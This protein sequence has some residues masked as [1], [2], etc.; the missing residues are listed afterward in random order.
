[1][2]FALSR[3]LNVVIFPSTNSFNVTLE[4]TAFV[5]EQISLLKAWQLSNNRCFDKLL[6]WGRPVGDDYWW[7]L[8]P[9]SRPWSRLFRL[10]R[11]FSTSFLDKEAY[12]R[13]SVNRGVN[14]LRMVESDLFQILADLFLNNFSCG[15]WIHPLYWK[16]RRWHARPFEASMVA[17]FLIALIRLECLNRRSM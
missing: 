14:L 1:M 7:W 3:L 12:L 9:A 8:T 11:R 17:Q 2:T 4:S 16:Q 6:V 10:L 13:I 5:C 15:V